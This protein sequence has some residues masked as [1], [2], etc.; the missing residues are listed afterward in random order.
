MRA[1]TRWMPLL[2]LLI[3]AAAAPGAQAPDA[4]PLTRNLALVQTLRIGDA[5]RESVVLLADVSP[6][7]IRYRWSFVEVHA[8]GD[9]VRD[10]YQ[11]FVSSADLDT[12]SRS[13]H[14]FDNSKP[15]HPGYTA[16]TIGRALYDQLH[17]SGTG[18]FSLL[19]VSEPDESSA[20]A[21]LPEAMA[22]VLGGPSL[23]VRWRGTLTRVSSQDEAFPLLFNGRRVSVP[24]MHLKADLTS[25]GQRWTP[26]LWILAQHDHPLILKLADARRVY[27]TVRVNLP[28]STV[29]SGAFDAALT[30]A[31][32]LEVPGIYFE[33]NSAMLKRESDAAL[34][35][36][37]E[38]LARHAD[39]RVTVEGHTDSIGSPRSNQT[40]SE[41]RAESVRAWLAG[42]GVAG[43]RMR[44]VGY[45]AAR[46]RETNTTV[47]GR[48]RNRRV[49]LV[50]PC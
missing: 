38:V 27:Q 22:R 41:R 13:D 42:H 1:H 20:R 16:Y 31:C 48:A 2:A 49:E 14:Y 35:S 17:T 24:A 32:R 4:I 8:N 7:G 3:R 36:L 9:T 29:S 19:T 25:R 45:G 37:A 33:F 6:A 34:G 26:E 40:L 28:D 10:N 43:T 12:A 23:V 50:R 15:E 30:K 5:E 39:W 18:E 11:R 47:E 44:A 46:P 21:H